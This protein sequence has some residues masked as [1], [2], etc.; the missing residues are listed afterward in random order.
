MTMGKTTRIEL[1]PEQER[2]LER[3]FKHTRNA[4][5]AERL[6]ISERSLIRIARR[7]GLAKSRQFMRAAQRNAADRARESHLRNG[8]YPPKGFIIPRSEEFRFKPGET[9]A[10]RIGKAGERRRIEKSAE[11][12]RRTFKEERSRRVFGLPQRTGLRVIR[13]PRYVAYQRYYLRKLGYIV[14]RGGF[15]AYYTPETRRSRR[16]EDRPRDSRRYVHFE[17]RDISEMPR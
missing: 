14:P 5:A 11:S 15:T 1:T 4:E 13:L 16:Y 6:G 12:R 7:L 9:S 3:H 8:T 17:F 2:W 10:Q